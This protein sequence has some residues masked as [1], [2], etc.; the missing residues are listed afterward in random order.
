MSKHIKVPNYP[1]VL[2]A[3]SPIK[4]GEVLKGGYVL[5]ENGIAMKETHNSEH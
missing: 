3:Y 5:D 1:G 2:N 4:W